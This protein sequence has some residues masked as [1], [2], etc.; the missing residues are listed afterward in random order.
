MTFRHGIWLRILCL[1]LLLPGGAS[2]VLAEETSAPLP[3]LL[4][5]I[6]SE[7]E[8][9]AD[10]IYL[11]GAVWADIDEPERTEKL[12]LMT[13]TAKSNGLKASPYCTAA[14][15]KGLLRVTGNGLKWRIECNKDGSIILLTANGE[16]YLY[17]KKDANLSLP[18]TGQSPWKVSCTD[19]LFRM[20]H[21]NEPDKQRYLS[22][23]Y[24]EKNTYKFGNYTAGYAEMQDLCIYKATVTTA[25]IPSEQPADGASVALCATG[26]IAD[27]AG[28][29]VSDEGILLQNGTLAQDKSYSTW[30]YRQRED[31]CFTLIDQ[32]GN[33]L[34]YTLTATPGETL[35]RMNGGNICTT[36]T[37]ARRLC[38]SDRLK[39]M[40]VTPEE[41]AATA[42]LRT[43]GTAPDSLITNGV[44]SLSGAWGAQQL[45]AV[46]WKGLYALDATALSLPVSFGGFAT[47]PEASNAL[48]YVHAEAASTIPADWPLTVACSETG[49]TLLTE[50]R[51]TDKAPF[52]TD[53][54]IR[55]AAGM[56]SYSRAA[57]TD[58]MWE[59]LCLPFPAEVP[60]GFLA[61]RLTGLDDGMLHFV[62]T[63][64]LPAYVPVIL[65]STASSAGKTASYGTESTTFS[66]TTTGGTLQPGTQFSE[67]GFTGTFVPL[68]ITAASEGLY[69]LNATGDT[70][71]LAGEGSSLKPF[72]AGIRLAPSARSLQIV[73]GDTPATGLSP[74]PAELCSTPCYTLDGRRVRIRLSPENHH[75]LPPGIYITGGKRIIIK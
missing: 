44:K 4:K 2:T 19:G 56:M 60:Q 8:L 64:I 66:V 58:G 34:D 54:E 21:S 32:A 12:F 71:V 69:L 75:S 6:H 72:R 27:T 53:R 43:C 20:I 17:N 22:L 7:S 39:L 48:L 25:G 74:A 10:G 47:R 37:P 26:L 5:R 23:Y 3:D 67:H 49:N 30:T 16:K 68:S 45:A 18:S 11:I 36:E 51:L 28:L 38:M 61:E 55:Y 1:L 73:H 62:P 41:T 15:A 50:S 40:P 31:S 42:F 65:R 57:Y 24:L 33:C 14:E 13:Q 9:T 29:A 52:V 70:F 63:D 35:W 59:T 46:D